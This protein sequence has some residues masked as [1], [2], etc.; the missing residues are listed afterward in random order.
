MKKRINKTNLAITFILLIYFLMATY[1]LNILLKVSNIS[2]FSSQN[3][4]Y[5]SRSLGMITCIGILLVVPQILII[6]IMPQYRN[7]TSLLHYAII[8]FAFIPAMDLNKL[9]QLFEGQGILSVSFDIKHSIQI[10][11]LVPFELIMLLLLLFIILFQYKTIINKRQILLFSFCIV[12][13]LVALFFPVLSDILLFVVVYLLTI[14]TFCWYE[15][16]LQLCGKHSEKL[17]LY[18][19][20]ILLVGRSLYRMLSIPHVYSNF[21]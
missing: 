15:T 18:T 14:T 2:Y 11:P 3:P 12:L 8:Y 19:L 5:V 13:V 21:L 7:M 17:I 1:C 4:E 9:L 20:L 10:L 6:W 16:L